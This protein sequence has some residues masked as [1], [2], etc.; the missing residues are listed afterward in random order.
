[1]LFIFLSIYLMFSTLLILQLLPATSILRCTTP[2]AS[3]C[4]LE[5]GSLLCCSSSMFPF[6]PNKI[7]SYKQ[8]CFDGLWDPQA[9]R[10]P[11]I[12]PKPNPPSQAHQTHPLDIL[13]VSQSNYKAFGRRLVGHVRVTDRAGHSRS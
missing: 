5:E 7:C 4:I 11:N 13:V 1:M 6:S 12:E 3:Q 9:K 2:V 8:T 10:D